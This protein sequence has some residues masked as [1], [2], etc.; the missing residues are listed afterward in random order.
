[1]F[2]NKYEGDTLAKEFYKLMELKKIASEGG[3]NVTTFDPQNFA[4]D[5]VI[6]P[7]QFLQ[8]LDK[9]PEISEDLSE[10]IN[11]LETWSD[12]SPELQ[13]PEAPEEKEMYSE[14]TDYLLDQRA[15]EVLNGLGKIAGSLKMRGEVFAADVVEATAASIQNDLIK[16]ASEKLETINVLTKI[17]S[18][19]SNNGDRF[20][21][22]I[23]E[24]AISKIKNN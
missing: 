24:A 12:E 21:A 4:E 23:V 2:G 17:A 9:H 19:I 7:S 5:E 13:M 11:K 10:N 14:D 20:T 1:M 3:E 8:S 15:S 18:D 16:E 22:D 6:D